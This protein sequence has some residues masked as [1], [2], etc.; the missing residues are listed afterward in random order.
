MACI[1]AT[2]GSPPDSSLLAI[3]LRVAG[4]LPPEESLV[5]SFDLDPDWAE[6]VAL[7]AAFQFVA[8]IRH[9]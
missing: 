4:T 8:S 2:N 6:K 9:Q 7:A 5:G 3:L 1:T